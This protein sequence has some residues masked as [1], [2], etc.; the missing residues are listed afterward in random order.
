MH[1]EI[2]APIEPSGLA[3]DERIRPDL[4]LLMDY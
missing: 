3:D 2:V 1:A 4:Q